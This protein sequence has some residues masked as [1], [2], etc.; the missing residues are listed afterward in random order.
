MPIQQPIAVL[1]MNVIQ[2]RGSFFQVS[3]T[4]LGLI[5]AAVPRKASPSSI[6]SRISPMPKSPMTAIRKSKPFIR[7][8]RPKV[9]RSCPVTVSMPIAE[10]AKPIIIEAMIFAA[11]P[12]PIPTKLQNVSR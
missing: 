11:E 6:D 12:L 1:R 8:V 5:F 2:N 9:R 3:S 7:L 10:S 4:T